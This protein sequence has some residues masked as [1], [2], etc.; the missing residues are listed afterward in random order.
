MKALTVLML[1][2][3]LGVVFASVGFAECAG[4]AKTA[5]VEAPTAPAP[6]STKT[7]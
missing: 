5:K 3:V 2:A 6:G 1:A 7:G 4:H